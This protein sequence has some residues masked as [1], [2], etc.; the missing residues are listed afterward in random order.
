MAMGRPDEAATAAD[1][2]LA[3]G[4]HARTADARRVALHLAL[5]R[6]D[7][8]RASI[9]L[10]EMDAP[11]DDLTVRTHMCTEGAP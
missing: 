4:G 9:L 10:S 11:D 8:A 1:E 7:C 6:Q 5:L 2:V 3:L